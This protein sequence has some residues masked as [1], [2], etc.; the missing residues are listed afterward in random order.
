M[1]KQRFLITGGSQGIGAAFGFNRLVET[2]TTLYLP[3][4]PGV[5]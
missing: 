3:A 4:Q 2:V 5:D 1:E